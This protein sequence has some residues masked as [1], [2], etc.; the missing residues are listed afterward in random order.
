MKARWITI[1]AVTV[2]MAALTPLSAQGAVRMQDPDDVSLETID[3]KSAVVEPYEVPGERFLAF[4]IESYE[5]LNCVDLQRDS[6]QSLGFVIDF[7][8]TPERHDA[9]F[10]VRCFQRS[11]GDFGIDFYYWTVRFPQTGIKH[12]MPSPDAPPDA[13]QMP[14]PTTVKILLDTDWYL[15][16]AEIPARWKV[17]SER[18]VD[19]KIAEIDTAP[20]RGWQDFGFEGSF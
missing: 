3:I 5:P 11:S 14:S 4:V 12:R 7:P 20:D 2:L 6:G 18:R 8:S 13:L 1:P 17:V 19:S 10:R 16:S 9:R 15:P